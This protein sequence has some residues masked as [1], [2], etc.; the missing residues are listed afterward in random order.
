MMISRNECIKCDEYCIGNQCP[1]KDIVVHYCDECTYR[2][3]DYIIDGIEL[4]ENCAEKFLN[5]EFNDLSV[6]EKADSLGFR[7]ET[8]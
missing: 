5:E 2:R 1:L 6:E 4:C 7:V 8:F 3:A